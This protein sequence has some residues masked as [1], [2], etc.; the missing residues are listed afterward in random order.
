MRKGV[1][2][3]VILLF[4]GL[5]CFRYIKINQAYPNPLCIDRHIGEAVL[6]EGMV[7]TVKDF[8]R[9]YLE[10]PEDQHTVLVDIAIQ[11]KAGDSFELP[12]LSIQ[13]GWNAVLPSYE[14]ILDQFGSVRVSFDV[15]ETKEYTLEYIFHKNLYYEKDW[16]T[17][18]KEDLYLEIT[19]TYPIR[20]IVLLDE[21]DL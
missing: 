13:D 10:E 14:S 3:G 15:D 18:G 11:G 2:F 4:I 9:D 12:R 20:N 5:F 19:D 7:I 8:H 16:E 17:W 21:N 1:I 6:C